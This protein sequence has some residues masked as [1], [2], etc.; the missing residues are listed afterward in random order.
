MILKDRKR[1]K[2]RCPSVVCCHVES[3]LKAIQVT[4]GFP[5]AD[6]V[7]VNLPHR[8]SPNQGKGCVNP[9]NQQ[10]FC[11]C[12]SNAAAVNYVQSRT[13]QYSGHIQHVPHTLMMV[14]NAEQHRK[15]RG[16]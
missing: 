13:G 14:T 2:P 16:V 10:H 15:C 3:R 12:D 5:S 9:V 6:G 1:R 7:H 4:R 11:C 8:Q